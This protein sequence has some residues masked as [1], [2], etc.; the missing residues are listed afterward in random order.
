MLLCLLPGN[1][2]CQETLEIE[3]VI[4]GACQRD[5]I[6]RAEV[7]DMTMRA[8][9]YSRKLTGDG[10][11]KEEKKFFKEYFYKDTLFKV[12][13]L[14]YYLENE[15]QSKKKLQEQIEEADK[16]RKQ[17]RS[18]DAS[19]NPMEPFYPQNRQHYRFSMPG[20]EKQHGCICYHITVVSLVEDEDLFEGDYWFETN[21]L[22]LVHAEFRPAR[23]PSKIKQLD[24]TMSYAPVEE[25]YWLP[26]GFHLLGRGK[27]LILIKFNFEVEEKYSQ[28][29]V[30][31][32]LT[33]D[34][35]AED[36]DE[37]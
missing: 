33:D 1:V 13:F 12:E 8:E 23:M 26:V 20:I 36:S 31:V 6:K 27:V 22:N 29:K 11:V 16:R 17:G 30:N 25:G 7:T 9:S 34:F 15:L 2:W 10:K 3:E 5:S 37:D 24:M 19:V 18:R 35:F 28:H 21:W 4:D 14:E 32:G